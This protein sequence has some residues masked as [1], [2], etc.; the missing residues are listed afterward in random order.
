MKFTETPLSG[1]YIIDLD[2]IE[3]ERGFF[4]RTF[5]VKEF[6]A[7]GIILNIVQA[8]TSYNKKRGTVRGMHYQLP[9][10]AEPK[11]IRCVRGSIYDVIIDLRE[12]S[13]TYLKWFA[14]E[15]NE[16]NQKM[17]YVPEGFAHGFQTLVDDTEVFYQMG[18]YYHQEA[19]T[20]VRWDDSKFQIFWPLEVAVISVKDRS[21]PLFHVK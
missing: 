19:A 16:Q 9:P 14:A 6:S 7:R 21:Y 8:N 1:A 20:G 3:D 15:L 13:E 18:E 11:L 5:C 4:A 12:D 17:I 2:R 10:H